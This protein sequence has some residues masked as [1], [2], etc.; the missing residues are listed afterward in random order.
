M[1][2]DGKLYNICGAANNPLTDRIIGFRHGKRYNEA[3]VGT[4]SDTRGVTNILFADGHAAGAPRGDLP[5]LK[6]TGAAL[7]NW[8]TGPATQRQIPKYYWNTRQ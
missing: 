1:V 6:T 4:D 3:I 7:Y 5:Y 8:M 2:F